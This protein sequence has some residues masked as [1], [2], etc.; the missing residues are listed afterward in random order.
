MF[1]SVVFY[2]AR[3]LLIGSGL[4][5]LLCI[6]GAFGILWQR[7]RALRAEIAA[8]EAWA[9]EIEAW[10][11]ESLLPATTPPPQP[12]QSSENAPSAAVD[13]ARLF[14]YQQCRA[15]RI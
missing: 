15:K 5:A 2:H 4:S 7:N 9:E 10:R 12:L 14:W 13:T 6:A 11:A 1:N 8:W 3:T